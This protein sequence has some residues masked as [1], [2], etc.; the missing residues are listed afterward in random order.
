MATDA[1]LREAYATMR[2]AFPAWAARQDTRSVR[3]WGDMLEDVPGEALVEAIKSL[4][5]S[6][7]FPPSVAEIREAAGC[8]DPELA[9]R[10]AAS[11]HAAE[12][13]RRWV[14]EQGR[15]ATE[16][17]RARLRRA[18]ID[19]DTIKPID[20]AELVKGIGR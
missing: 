6:A 13:H 8:E 18:G 12:D 7:T 16:E 11:Q 3:I 4:A 2:A 9:R 19:P 5:K 10:R 1:E 17:A 14:A 20:I 15:R